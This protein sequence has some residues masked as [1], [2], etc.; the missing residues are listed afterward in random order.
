MRQVEIPSPYL[1]FLDDARDDLAA[2]MA[3]ACAEWRPERCVGQLRGPRCRA[4]ARLPDLSIDEAVRRGAKSFVVGV[5]AAGGALN[6]EWIP[7]FVAAIEAGMDVVSGMHQRLA[8]CT[9][10]AAAAARCGRRLFDIRHPTRSFTTATGAPR[11][12]RRLLTVGSDCSCGKMFTALSIER[13][14]RRR[15]IDA[16]FRATGQTGILISGRGVAVDAVVADFMAGA[17]E[18]LAPA[19]DSAHWDLIE[20]QGSLFHPAFAGVSLALLHGAQPEAIVMCHEPT[21]PHLRGL[22]HAR[23]PAVAECIDANL[24]AARIVSPNVRCAGVSL[25][26]SKLDR[27]AAATAKARVADET[28]LPVVDPAIDGAGALVDRIL[29]ARP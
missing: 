27:P 9:P 18:W 29:E 8:D 4:D 21:R 19:A 12:G 24:R 1:L 15:G 26:T 16:E 20:G 6:D 25:N 3:I 7:V 28:G 17:I 5:V 23:V 14:M 13:E 11:E 22:P 2:K 10:V